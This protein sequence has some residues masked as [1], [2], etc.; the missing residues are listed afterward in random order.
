MMNRHQEK[1]GM[2]QEQSQSDKFKE[3]ARQADCDEDESAFEEK[4]RRLGS[5]KPRDEDKTGS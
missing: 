4:L 2:K 3:A 1:D 5:F